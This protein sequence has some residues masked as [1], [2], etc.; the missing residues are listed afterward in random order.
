M[1]S[2]LPNRNPNLT[3][4]EDIRIRIRNLEKQRQEITNRPDSTSVALQGIDERIKVLRAMDKDLQS[5]R[6]NRSAVVGDKTCR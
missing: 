4:S 3:L 6:T 5:R 1:Y 2:R